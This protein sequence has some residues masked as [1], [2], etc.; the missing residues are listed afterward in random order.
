MADDDILGGAAKGAAS[1]AMAGGPWG[2]AA[3]AGIGVL[4]PFIAKGLGSLFGLD[5]PS[6]EEQ[7][8]IGQLRSVAQGAQ[9]PAQLM[10]AAQRAKTQQQL[11]SMAARGTAQQ[12]AGQT[13]MAMQM[14]PEIQA[15]QAAQ[16]AAIRAQE[17]RSAQEALAGLQANVGARTRQYERGLVGAGLQGGMAMAA[18]AFL[19]GGG[20]GGGAADT[21]AAD[22]ALK[23]QLGITSA[24]YGG[25]APATSADYA[26]ELG[27]TSPSA[28]A[29]APAAGGMTPTQ[30]TNLQTAV[31]QVQTPAAPAASATPAHLARGLVGV[32][33]SEQRM[34]QQAAAQ[35]SLPAYQRRGLAPVTASEQRM[36]QERFAEAFPGAGEA[37]SFGAAQNM[38]DFNRGNI[39]RQ[40]GTLPKSLGAQT[41]AA[42]AQVNLGQS[43]G[44]LQSTIDARTMGLGGQALGVPMRRKLG[45]GYGY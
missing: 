36:Q 12:Q 32:T 20:G 17:Q 9:T 35:A 38:Y 29:A 2:A 44:G 40:V 5:Q 23:K 27:F 37:G 24:T 34:Q 42:P 8:A 13:R 33:P 26:R 18:N 39:E 14:A 41:T 28:Q 11:A 19:G 31:Q 45:F 25:E 16:M 1:G 22:E 10:L 3:G 6:A 21:T 4:S 43:V 7:A 15:Q 30:A